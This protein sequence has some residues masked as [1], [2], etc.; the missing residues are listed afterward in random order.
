MLFKPVNIPNELQ[1]LQQKSP[2]LLNQVQAILRASENTDKDIYQRLKSGK[3]ESRENIDL[4]QLDDSK[5]FSLSIIETTCVKYRLRFL[6]STHFKTELPYSAIQAV[7]AFEKQH[8]VKVQQFK[9]LAPYGMFQLSDKNEDPLLFA[10]L[11]DSQFYLLHKWGNDLTWYRALLNYPIQSIY[12]FFISTICFAAL[13]AWIIP[14]SWLNV[15]KESEMLFRFWLNT[16]FTIAFFFFFL[17]LG[18]L[19]NAS[20]SDSSWDS[21]HYN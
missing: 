2:E 3:I 8:Q 16:H 10:Q 17:F 14:F 21:K 9:I 5:I 6:D 13:V 11:S 4:P 12:S 20:F 18:S 7:N 19:S 1:K 15:Q